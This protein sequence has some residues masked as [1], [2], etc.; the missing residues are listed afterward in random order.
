MLEEMLDTID[1][2]FK[3]DIEQFKINISKLRNKLESSYRIIDSSLLKELES[4]IG[5]L[6]KKINAPLNKAVVTEI[7]LE[8]S[9]LD[10][11]IGELNAYFT[12]INKVKYISE[13]LGTISKENLLECVG[14]MT[15]LIDELNRN[16]LF[17]LNSQSKKVE[18]TYKVAYN[19]IKKEILIN[20]SSLLLS[21][22]KDDEISSS[23]IC[24]LIFSEIKEIFDMTCANPKA[25]KNLETVLSKITSNEIARVLDNEVIKSILL[26]TDY[27]ELKDSF[28]K[29]FM[30]ERGQLEVELLKE[31]STI[32]DDISTAIE[33]KKNKI[34]E[35]KKKTK[36]I[37][38]P[39]ILLLMVISAIAS[40][41][42]SLNNIDKNKTKYNTETL[43]YVDTSDEIIRTTDVETKLTDALHTEYNL[44]GELFEFETKRTLEICGETYFDEN[45]HPLYTYTLYDVN[46]YLFE[47]YSNYEKIDESD[48]QDKIIESG[49][50]KGEPLFHSKVEIKTQD[51]RNKI[52]DE[53]TIKSRKFSIA[54]LGF[55]VILNFPVQTYYLFSNL[56]KRFKLK[57]LIKK[58]TPKIESLINRCNDNKL[59]ISYLKELSNQLKAL[60]QVESF[61]SE[62]VALLDVSEIESENNRLIKKL[63]EDIVI[64]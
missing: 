52:L 2:P 64:D 46:D 47:D 22:I 20:H 42:V 9:L 6:E 44:N 29:E 63:H 15:E 53:D 5:S 30:G 26:V 39:T 56:K 41:V 10:K 36:S 28:L 34:L 49:I 4:R 61:T 57:S 3:K 18:M 62:E 17:H 21:A 19:L 23:Y 14:M 35:L 59:R 11:K 33:E 50:K 43:I 25:I 16:E 58:N 1:Y 51:T 8:L 54:L 37:I 12:M 38:S 13:S 32:D 40:G 60:S 45:W 27:E 7:R 48:L 24:R 31:K 55:N